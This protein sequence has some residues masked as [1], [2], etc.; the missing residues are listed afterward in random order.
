MKTSLIVERYKTL[1]QYI[2]WQDEDAQRIQEAQ[3][4]LLPH[5]NPVIDDFYATIEKFPEAVK[6]I[7]GGSAQIERLKQTLHGWVR[8]LLTGPYEQDYILRR[9][10]V[11]YRHVE[12]G[13]DQMYADAALSRMRHQLMELLEQYW[14]K[15]QESLRSTLASLRKLMDLEFAI[16]AS[17]Y[18]AEYLVRLQNS[19][20]FA[21]LGQVTGGIAHEMRNPLNVIKTSVYFLQNARALTPEKSAEHLR[22]IEKQVQV[23]ENVI[24]ALSSFAKQPQPN[25]QAFS[26]EVC[27]RRAVEDAAL[28]S[29]IQVE[30]VSAPDLPQA[31][32]DEDQIRIVLANLVHNARDVMPKGGRLTISLDHLD[33]QICFQVADTGPGIPH[34]ILHQVLEPFFTTK[35]RGIGLGL[36][37]SRSIAERNRGTLSASSP[38][39]SGA[40]FHLR[41]P[42]SPTVAT[43]DTKAL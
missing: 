9:W 4:I 29:S 17:A 36:A 35:A 41:L 26:P 27:V 31:L 5:L 30:V 11:G 42:A 12:I 14:T 10:K 43:T 25:S 34:E 19:E 40:T 32:G 24:A 39:G 8:E 28:P 18:Q 21:A 38:P 20:R 7:T 15:S 23:A 6:V 37:I 22:R 1:Q 16:I 33:G 2:G 3:A 13:L